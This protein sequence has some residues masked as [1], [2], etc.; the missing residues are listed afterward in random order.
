MI[1]KL[2][3]LSKKINEQILIKNFT[4]EFKERGFYIILGESGCGKTTLLNILSLIDTN[5]EGLYLIND[6][7]AFRYKE[8][9]K[10]SLRSNKFSYI[11]Q[12]FN[13]FDDDTVFNN[14]LIT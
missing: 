8:V 9:E 3:K 4:F 1:L 6:N 2:K 5:Y 7:D 12:N 13:L 10:C 14:I 11:F